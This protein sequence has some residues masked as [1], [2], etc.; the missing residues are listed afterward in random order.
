MPVE[1]GVEVDSRPVIPWI[2]V[3]TGVETSA[4]T[5]SGDAPG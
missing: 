4:S 3:S 1:L 5:T 2:A